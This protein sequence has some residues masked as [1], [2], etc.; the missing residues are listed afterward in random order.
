MRHST[1]ATLVLV[2]LFASIARAGASTQSTTV[3]SVT[4]TFSYRGSPPITKDPH[5]T[6]TVRGKVVYDQVVRSTSCSNT[7]SPNVIA[8]SRRVVHIVR[9]EQSDLP[10][11]VLDLYTG[12][13]H[14]CAIEEV[15]SFRTNSM[16]VQKTEHN[17]GD[18]GV[19]LVR[20][21]AGGTFDLLSANDAFAYAFTDF[22]AS[23]L[24]IQILSFSHNR[25]HD[26][27]RSF[28]HLI[29][30]D[31]RLWMNAFNSEASTHYQDSV[32]VVAAWAAD[33]DMLGHETTVARFLANQAKAG[34]LNSA[35]SPITPS[36]EHYVIALQ[37]FLRHQRY[38]R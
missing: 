20:L 38:V 25:F 19:R 15:F 23:G 8:G 13:A 22:A 36:G 18:P 31:A 37:K 11:V 14:C 16:V 10:N 5:L 3:G 32:G 21:G 29:A 12:G 9:L 6:I 34:H 2:L 30:Q 7:C 35:L 17:F 27:T 1:I 26:V 28:P 24:P 4:A 33:E